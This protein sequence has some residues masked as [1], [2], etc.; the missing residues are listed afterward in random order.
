MPATGVSRK[1][2]P[3]VPDNTVPVR[4]PA[5]WGL[6]LRYSGGGESRT[7]HVTMLCF[8][9]VLLLSPFLLRYESGGDGLS[10][11]G[12]VLPAI[13]L[14]QR[15]LNFE[16]PGC[17][18]CRSFVRLTHGDLLGAIQS[19]RLGPLLYVFLVAVALYRICAIRWP[20]SPRLRRTAAM[21]HYGGWAVTGALSLNW[22]LGLGL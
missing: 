19:H 21:L 18:L 13:C 5:F 17:G 4:R 1:H 16:C 11:A 2:E 3:R 14:S 22:L 6:T 9:M 12:R 20:D 15:L 8:C 7:G 10:I